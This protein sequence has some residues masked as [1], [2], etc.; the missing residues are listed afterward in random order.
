[1][2]FSATSSSTSEHRLRINSAELSNIPSQAHSD[3]AELKRQLFWDRRYNHGK[4]ASPEERNAEAQRRSKHERLLYADN[5]TIYL[6]AHPSQT[7]SSGSNDPTSS[8]TS[9]S[10]DAT[11]A[12][13]E[14]RHL[15]RL[16]LA[17]NREAD[18]HELVHEGGQAWSAGGVD[19]PDSM[20][21]YVPSFGEVEAEQ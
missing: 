12:D 19:N 15:P 14:P 10:N 6:N 4:K 7:S 21:I 17:G 11:G 9:S 5:P 1:M 13:T 3:T 16:A 20:L 18:Y 8:S 2:T